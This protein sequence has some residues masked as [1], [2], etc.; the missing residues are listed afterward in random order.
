MRLAYVGMNPASRKVIHQIG[1]AS[2]QPQRKIAL[3]IERGLHAT[4]GLQLAGQSG[5]H[6][7]HNYQHHNQ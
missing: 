1:A 4:I 6:T 7:N 5:T 2:R 3:G